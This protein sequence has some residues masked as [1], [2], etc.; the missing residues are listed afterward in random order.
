VVRVPALDEPEAQLLEA[1]P[2]AE[3]EPEPETYTFKDALEPEV[4]RPVRLA[5]PDTS[6]DDEEED[7]EPARPRRRRR[8]RRREVVGPP[9]GL[10]KL[11]HLYWLFALTL[12][13]LGIMLAREDAG[14][15]DLEERLERTIAKAPEDVRGRVERLKTDE[16]ADLDELLTALPE[17]RIEGAHLPRDSKRHWFYALAAGVA[18]FSVLVLISVLDRARPLSLLGVGVLTGTVGV[19]LLLLFQLFA[20]ITQGVFVV[21]RSAFVIFFWIAKFIGFS[22]QAALDPANGFFPSFFGFLFGVGFCEELCKAFPLIVMFFSSVQLSW[23]GAL[24]WGLASGIGFGVS[25]GLIYS[26]SMYN[27]ITGSEVYLVRFISCVALHAM[28]TGTVGVSLYRWRDLFNEQVDWYEYIPRILLVLGIPMI[29]HAL[30]DTLLKKEMSWM[31]LLVA[32]VS[33]AWFAWQIEAVRRE[34]GEPVLS[35][36]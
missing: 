23:R 8:S 10:G 2:Y 22:Y 17:R 19:F 11:H 36:A 1:I 14:R 24:L 18:F 30:Y 4:R 7:D 26:G 20:A 33:F 25:E 21:G 29:L 9:E 31:A 12:I 28:W 34:E 35:A 15:D 16:D 27:G 32:V 6:E 5:L 13:P 3:P